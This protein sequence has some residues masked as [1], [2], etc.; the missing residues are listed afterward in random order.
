M[1]AMIVSV[2]KKEKQKM[3]SSNGGREVDPCNEPNSQKWFVV[4]SAKL[5]PTVEFPR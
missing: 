5:A 4:R 3:A 2:S 1:K